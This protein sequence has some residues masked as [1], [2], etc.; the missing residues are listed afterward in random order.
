MS[1]VKVLVGCELWEPYHTPSSY[2]IQYYLIIV[3]DYSFAIWV[4]L[5]CNKTK[6]MF[7][8][9]ELYSLCW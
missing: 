8:F 1:I 7:M 9:Y 2:G 6:V 3:N 4:Y 5:L